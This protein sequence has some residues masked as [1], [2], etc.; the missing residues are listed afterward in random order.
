MK[1]VIAKDIL[2]FFSI[3]NEYEYTMSLSYISLMFDIIIYHTHK[4]Q[5]NILTLGN[6]QISTRSIIF[7]YL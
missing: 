1:N 2:L 4:Y 6:A 5:M 3:N 7:S